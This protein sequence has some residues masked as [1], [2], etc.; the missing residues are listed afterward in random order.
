MQSVSIITNFISP[1][2]ASFTPYNFTF[3]G[4]SVVSLLDTQVSCTEKTDSH[5]ITA[6][7]LKEKLEDTKG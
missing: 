5:D 7:L 1:L 6:I 3:F 4:R 2:L